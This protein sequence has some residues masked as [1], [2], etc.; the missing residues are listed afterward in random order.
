MGLYDRLARFFSVF[1]VPRESLLRLS[2]LVIVL[3]VGLL[4]RLQPV[5]R[6]GVNHRAYDPFIQ[7]L[8]TQILLEKGLWGML[9][10]YDFKF[11]YPY[12][13]SLS[14]LYIVVPILGAIIYIL[15]NTFGIH[16]DILTAITVTPAIIGTLTVIVVYMLGKEIKNP[17]V[18]L[19]AAIL[20]AVSPGYIQRSIAGF[21]DNEMTIF[22]LLLA[23]LFF[24]RSIKYGKIYD[25]LLSGFLVGVV[26][27]SWGIWRY[28]VAILTLYV[29]I[30]LISG[31]LDDKDRLTFIITMTIGI[32]IGVMIP[33]NYGAITGIEVSSALAVVVLLLLDYLA[34]IFASIYGKTRYQMYKI[35][36]IG[37]LV[38]IAVGIPIL[39]MMGYLTPITGKFASV[40]NPF[41]R[42]KIVTYT[43]VAENQ[44]GV[45]AN[46]YLAVGPG[47]L[48]IP[49][50]ILA[51]I[52]RR[53]K[54]DFLLFLFVA[55]SFYF[56]ASITRYV[57]LGASIFALA[58]GLG[59]DYLL[60]PYARF[61]SGRY[62]LHKA[63]VVRRYLG[64]RRV[65]KGEALSVYLVVL[66]VLSISVIQGITISGFYSSYDFTDAEKAIFNY[67]KKYAESSDVVLSWWD[68]G[69]RC[70]IVANVTTLADNGTRNSTQMGV[71]GS[72]L[73]LPPDK[74]IVLMRMY[75]VKWILVYSDD[76]AKAIWMIKIASKHAPMYGVHEKDYLNEE[77]LRYKEPFFHSVL[78]VALAY[79][80]GATA[81]NWVKT[82]GESKLKD[83]ASEFRVENLVYFVLVMK[84]TYGRRFVKL[85][86]VV[87]PEEFKDMASLPPTFNATTLLNKTQIST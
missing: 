50:A 17:N 30:R 70:T 26:M 46:F 57:V 54:I 15:L 72:M 77:E 42:E 67:L 76:L 14:A 68:Y 7:Y 40:L 32:G 48:L 33:R 52:E 85:Y 87:W 10:Y 55:T 19:I 27:W 81:D 59:V 45:W 79:R 83:R 21:Y 38:I 16:V 36:V 71:V 56:T 73:M 62:I 49:P 22:F 63:R 25:A 5:L 53:T 3:A 74:S 84:K 28:L 8:A 66:L 12:G 39:L 44:P 58:V 60:S 1:R 51:M 24:T 47:I 6:Y 41:L 78:W 11:W 35:F 43:S 75:N 20:T 69:Y 65:P 64:E 80:E 31:S 2:V 18:G 9:T 34:T 4:L 61:F 29:F 13:N 23:V 37:G 82:Y 86:R